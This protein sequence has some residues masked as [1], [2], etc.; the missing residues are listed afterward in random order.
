M[1]FI[2]DKAKIVKIIEGIEKYAKA[3]KRDRIN[4]MEVCGTHTN[5]IMKSGISSVIP[6]KIR[7][8]SGPGCPVCVTSEHYID[9]AIHLAE[10]DKIIVTFGDLMRVKGN[11]HD[12]LIERA[13]GKDIRVVYSISEVIDIAKENYPKEVIFLSVGFETTTP[14]IGALVKQTYFEN[15]LNLSFLT[16]LK[17]MPPILNKILSNEEKDI[18]GIICPGNVCVITGSNNFKFI[19]TTYNIPSVVCGFEGEDI[20]AGVYY[21]VKTIYEMENNIQTAGFKNLYVPWVKEEG[22]MICRKSIEE[23]F[24]KEDVVWRG[25][26]NVEKSAYTINQ[27]FSHLDANQRFDLQEYFNKKS[28]LENNLCKCDQVLL[29]R[30]YPFQCELFG[31]KCN[32]EKPF[33]PCMV[34]QEGT[35]HTYFKYGNYR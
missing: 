24:E 18:Q 14:L 25:I 16:S 26:G 21:L 12:L 31:K 28:I 3:I 30:I 5:S 27:R 33:G 34:S 20:L 13:R 2:K 4:I 6:S 9:A 23:V 19:W 15:I 8:V 22:N 17:S 35:C 1:I 10:E 11:E 29:G 32:P 7:L